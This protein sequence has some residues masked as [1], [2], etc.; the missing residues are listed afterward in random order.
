MRTTE[1]GLSVERLRQVLSYDPATGAIAWKISRGRSKAGAPAGNRHCK[2]YRIVRIDGKNH[3][4]HRVA[5]AHANGYW[6]DSDIDHANCLRADNRIEN[7]RAA[8]RSQ[9]LAN[10][11]PRGGRTGVKGVYPSGG[12]YRAQ[13][14]V[15]SRQRYLGT[16]DTPELASEA[17]K[18]TA[19]EVFGAFARSD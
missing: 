14:Q 3:L 13:I 17:Y 11:A 8:T 6:P 4:V 19:N 5:F 7:L 15:N 18:R 1:R 10:M 12:K 2:G 9:N 16:F